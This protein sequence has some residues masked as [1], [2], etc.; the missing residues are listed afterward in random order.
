MY[1]WFLGPTLTFRTTG[2][3]RF[4]WYEQLTRLEAYQWNRK[5]WT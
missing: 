4:S 2:S 5:S 3:Y 1:W